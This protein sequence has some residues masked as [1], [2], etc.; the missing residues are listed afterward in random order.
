MN[1]ETQTA[2]PTTVD[3][4]DE[5]QASGVAEV[6]ERIG[7]DLGG[8]EDHD[9]GAEEEKPDHLWRFTQWCPGQD[10]NLGPLA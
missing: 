9:E 2:P 7:E 5:Y 4:A 1:A 10:S 8:D 3:L 6:L